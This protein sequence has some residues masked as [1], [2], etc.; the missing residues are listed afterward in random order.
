MDMK[1]TKQEETAALNMEVPAKLLNQFDIWVKENMFSNR[2]EAVRYLMRRA[3]SRQEDL[4]HCSLK[5]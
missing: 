1:E 2:S 4:Q 3:I 5:S